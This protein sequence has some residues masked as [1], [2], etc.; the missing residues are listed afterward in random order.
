MI[1]ANGGTPPYLFFLNNTAEA[2]STFNNLVAGAYTARVTDSNGCESDI[3]FEIGEDSCEELD[4][5]QVSDGDCALVNHGFFD[6]ISCEPIANAESYVWEFSTESGA[7]FEHETIDETILASSVPQITPNTTY[8]IRVKGNAAGYNSTFGGS[9]DLIFN[10]GTSQLVE[11]YCGASELTFNDQID[12]DE[13]TGA[14]DYE[15]RFEDVETQERFYFYSGQTPSC[16]LNGVDGLEV[17]KAYEVVIRTKYRNTWSAQ[18]GI[19]MIAIV[20]VPLTTSLMAQWCNN[21][22]INREFDALEVQPIENAT[23]Y[24]LRISDGDLESVLLIDSDSNTFD[25]SERDDLNPSIKYTV[26][27][28]ALVED[29]WTNWGDACEIAFLEQ[30]EIKLNMLVYPNPVRVGESISLLTKGDW[31]NIVLQLYNPRGHQI[32]ITRSNFENMVPQEFI[33]PKL[34]PGIYFLRV[35]HGKQ[36][37]AKKIIVS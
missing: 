2:G 22:F 4:G 9:C 24:Q 36:M 20:P 5:T 31:K 27:A 33:L 13:V 35:I 37:L 1:S 3:D 28:R 14:T 11:I 8:A 29:I 12:A 23:V 15:F 26:Q 18:G 30:E 34:K 17:D 6:P 25:I 21:N 19:C 32:K 10:I 16:D 7:V